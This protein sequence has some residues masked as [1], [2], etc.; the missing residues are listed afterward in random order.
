MLLPTVHSADGWMNARRG[1]LLADRATALR[2]QIQQPCAVGCLQ[3]VEMLRPHM[4]AA[5]P[6]RPA[7]LDLHAVDLKAT[8]TGGVEMRQW[9]VPEPDSNRST[10]RGSGPQAALVR[11]WS[12][13]L[14]AASRTWAPVIEDCCETRGQ[15]LQQKRARLL[16]YDSA[17]A[18]AVATGRAGEEELE[19]LDEVLSSAVR[20]EAEV[21]ERQDSS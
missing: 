5:M 3:A 16:M 13:V 8:G 15:L 9:A 6:G 1:A 14:L 2:W 10:F 20:A 18:S 21:R 12:T 17:G 4:G 11:E 19:A 7:S